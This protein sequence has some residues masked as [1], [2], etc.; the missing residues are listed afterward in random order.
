MVK[1]TPQ[2]EM[3]A[4]L[5]GRSPASA[6][7]RRAFSRVPH[8]PNC[9]MCAAPFAGPGGAVLRHVGF[10]RFAGNPTICDFCIKDLQRMG[11]QGAEIPV[12]LLF[13]DIRGSTGIGE[14]LSP[15]AFR[16]FL[17]RFYRI[18][19]ESVLANDGLVDKFV[20]DEVIGLFFGGISGDRHAA[21]AIDAGRSLLER[22]GRPDA[23]PTGPIPVG[24]AVHTGMAFVGSTATDGVVSDFTALGDVV[25]TT[26][27]LATVA[28]SRRA[29]RLGRGGHGSRG[30]R[31][32]RRTSHRRGPGPDRT[33][34]RHLDPGRRPAGR[35]GIGVVSAPDPST[36]RH[37]VV[38]V[39]GGFAG[40]YAA[41]SLGDDDRLSVTLVDRRNFHLFQ[42]LL[43][44]VATGALSPG[45]IAQP[46]RAILRK[47]RRTTVLLG[48][49]VGL[50]PDAREVILSDGGTVAYDSLIVATGAR[51]SYFGHEAWQPF[52]PGLKTIEDAI[53]I[54][55]RILIAFEAAER[56]ADPAK[57]R[58]WM[59]FV[60][61]G[62]GP[63]GVELAGALGEIANDTLRRDFRAINPP[64]AHIVLIEAL[65]RI[66]PTYPPGLSRSAAR[67]LDRLG[68]RVRT[69]TRVTDVDEH[70]VTVQTGDQVE[71]IPA[72]TVAVGGRR[73]G[74]LVRP[75]RGR[76]PPDRDGPGRTDRGRS[77]PHRSRATPRSSSWATSRSLPGTGRRRCPAWHPPRSRKGATSRGTIRR[78]VRGEPVPPFRYR[79]RGDVATIGRLSGVADIR[80]LGR[81]GRMSGFLAWMMWLGIH[82]VYLVGFSNRLVVIIRWTWSFFTRGRNTRLITEGLL[83]PPI[84]RRRPATRTEP[85]DARPA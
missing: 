70:S 83:L 37:R 27:R 8:G 49:A 85:S 62:G 15:T 20:G 40:L 41:K 81:L 14:R 23:T 32:R 12:S 16:A 54:R 34:G 38:I 63:T 24:A 56:E 1:P 53:E 18:A 78:R 59:T 61:V 69:S 73:P 2:E 36:D 82:I 72:R 28:A 4:F 9:K 64:D 5:T 46:L 51:H 47:K 58:E 17:D 7:L 29:A 65:D 25:N 84:E 6:V 42:P 39:G 45:E 31:R 79:D 52:A 26:A 67:Q 10:G 55:R 80:W 43:Y 76:G 21:A 57:Q 75:A 3:H 77:G 50:D 30:G 19:S 35:V 68:A 48:E 60:V 22:A 71:R 66:L 44:Q 33:D 74:L 13:A 11:V